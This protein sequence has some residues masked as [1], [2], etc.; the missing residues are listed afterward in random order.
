MGEPV[1]LKFQVK[2][3]CK[4]H[5]TAVIRQNLKN[6]LLVELKMTGTDA[7]PGIRFV[8]PSGDMV[9]EIDEITYSCNDVLHFCNS[10]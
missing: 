3:I 4:P 5:K 8:A 1:I 6:C 9:V 2:L 10:S 7:V